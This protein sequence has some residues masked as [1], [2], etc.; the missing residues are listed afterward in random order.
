MSNQKTINKLKENIIEGKKNFVGTKP[1]YCDIQDSCKMLSDAVV[2]YNKVVEQNQSL[3]K[4]I[5]WQ[6][7]QMEKDNQYIVKLE[8]ANMLLL[9][10]VEQND[11]RTTNLIYPLEQDVDVLKKQVESLKAELLKK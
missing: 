1:L 7:E 6:K 8:E 9:Q 5:L 11:V 4:Q 2:Q 3:Q 10:Q